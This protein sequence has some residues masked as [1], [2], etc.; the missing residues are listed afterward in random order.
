MN[1]LDSTDTIE[2]KLLGAKV[3][4]FCETFSNALLVHLGGSLYGSASNI[5]AS[6]GLSS[7][8]YYSDKKIDDV[9][10]VVYRAYKT[11]LKILCVERGKYDKVLQE[12][13]CF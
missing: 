12:N 2:Y 8:V 7:L 9:I 6:A 13:L 1:G 10:P 3:L 11:R 5:L 4:S